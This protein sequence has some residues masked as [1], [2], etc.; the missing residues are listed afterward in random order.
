MFSVYGE[1]TF[2]LAVG[3]ITDSDFLCG[4]LVEGSQNCATFAAIK[5]DVFQL[6]EDPASAGN[7]PGNTDKVIQ[8]CPSEIPQRRAEGQIGNANMNFGVD[9]LV[10]RIV[11]KNGIK[12]D[13]IKNFQHWGWGICQE[14]RQ[15][16]FREGEMKIGHLQ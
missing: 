15:D 1:W 8:V 14:I 12:S 2:T 5:L 16:G 9:A 11:D 10:R 7:N 4:V 6:R 3:T 13:L